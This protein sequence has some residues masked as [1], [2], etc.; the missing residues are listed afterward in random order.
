MP[1]GF[2]EKLKQNIRYLKESLSKFM[3]SSEKLVLLCNKEDVDLVVKAAREAFDLGPWPRMSGL[4]LSP[5]FVYPPELQI[6]YV[7]P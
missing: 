1:K 3:G 6:C 4:Q 5:T 2:A 7:M